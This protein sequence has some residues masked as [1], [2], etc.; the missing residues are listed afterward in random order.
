MALKTI[1][2]TGANGQLGK[3]LQELSSQ[4]CNRYHFIFTDV[5]TLDITDILSVRKTVTSYQVNY[6][7]NAA[8]YTAVDKAE[9]E[10]E[11]AFLLNKTA[12]ENLAI[13]AKEAH[14]M[15]VHISTDYVFDGKASTPYQVN[16]QPNPISVYGKSKWEGEQ[17]IRAHGCN[18]AI[19]RT[20]WLYSPFG[21]N[22]VKTMLRL[23]DTHDEINV[24]D[25]Q[26]G[27]PTLAADLADFIMFLIDKIQ[28]E[29]G[30]EIYHFANQGKISWCGFATKI[31]E[32]ANKKCQ[33]NPIPTNAYPTLAKRP[34]F[35]VFDLSKV[36][37][38]LHYDI[39][40]W[41]ESLVKILPRIIY[42]YEHNI[43]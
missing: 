9:N 12:V 22:F 2:V 5:D 10:V 30:V 25:D 4:F 40:Y 26:I 33:V 29:K 8:A 27:A 19:I 39:P 18:A 11:K 42:N 3:S 21:N 14:A 7:I 36:T 37:C 24:V 1:L 15:L 6:I 17:A 23:A 38:N 20:E 35:S 28:I 31:M 34:N 13:V 32:L 41:E 16:D 43:L